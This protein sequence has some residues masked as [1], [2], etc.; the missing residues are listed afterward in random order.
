MQW[1]ARRTSRFVLLWPVELRKRF[2]L[3]D[4]SEKKCFCVLHRFMTSL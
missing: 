3:G 1:L 2:W 4:C